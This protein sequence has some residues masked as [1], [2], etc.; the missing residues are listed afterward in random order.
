MNAYLNKFH[1]NFYENKL[2]A[3][4]ILKQFIFTDSPRIHPNTRLKRLP[5]VSILKNVRLYVDCPN[6]IDW[7]SHPEN[8]QTCPCWH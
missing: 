6:A 1:E 3:S 8:P 5:D 2:N 4:L 7:T